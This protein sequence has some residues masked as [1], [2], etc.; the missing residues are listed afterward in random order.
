M[1]ETGREESVGNAAAVDLEGETVGEEGVV[2]EATIETETMVEGMT[3]SLDEATGEILIGVAHDIRG[4]LQDG[5][6]IP[7]TVGQLDGKQIPTYL[8]GEVD[9]DAMKE[10]DCQHLNLLYGLLLRGL[11]RGLVLHR[12]LGAVPC[13]D[14][15]RPP[16]AGAGPYPVHQRDAVVIGVEEGEKEG[17]EGARIV[18]LADGHHLLIHH[19]LHH[20]SVDGQYR[21]L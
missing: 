8:A 10:G 14:L 19:A 9:Q 4:L 21:T 1:S 20:P 2:D 13:Q 7:E 12:E 11:L 17:E 5:G 18:G 16:L 3:G 6:V 15:H